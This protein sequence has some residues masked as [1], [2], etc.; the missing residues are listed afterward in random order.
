[1]KEDRSFFQF[2]PFFSFSS[3]KRRKNDEQKERDGH[4]W[5]WKK[6]TRVK[7]ARER[8]EGWARLW[9]SKEKKVGGRKERKTEE[10]ENEKERGESW[11]SRNNA[12]VWE[13]NSVINSLFSSFHLLHP[14]PFHP[15][16]FF[17]PIL[18][19]S[20][21]FCSEERRKI[22]KQQLITNCLFIKSKNRKQDHKIWTTVI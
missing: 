21:P 17:I 6:D 9:K 11:E 13:K 18:F 7:K 19:H 3:L 16:P 10:E 8:N 14:L 15:H 1:M 2:L 22:S 20:H 4:L 12:N 5:F